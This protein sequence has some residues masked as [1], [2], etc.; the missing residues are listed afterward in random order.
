MKNLKDIISDVEATH[1]D[2]R[3]EMLFNDYKNNK[4]NYNQQFI[5]D[6]RDEL[7]KILNKED[8]VNDFW[9]KDISQLD[10]I[11]SQGASITEVH[12]WLVYL[13]MLWSEYRSFDG[14]DENILSDNVLIEF[15]EQRGRF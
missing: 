5:Y 11:P 10:N 3:L 7:S 2:L 6:L 4:R 8:F 9:F 14:F 15:K 1:R 12:D 13:R